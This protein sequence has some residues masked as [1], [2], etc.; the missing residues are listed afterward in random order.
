MNA[1]AKF[2]IGLII[3]GLLSLSAELILNQK[4]PD[5]KPSWVHEVQWQNKPENAAKIEVL[6]WTEITPY[7]TEYDAVNLS[8]SPEGG[9]LHLRVTA[10]TKDSDKPDIYDFVYENSELLPTG[11]LLEA[12]PPAYINEA[13][14]T[15]LGNQTVAASVTNSGNPTVRR[16]LPMTSEKFYEPK[17]LLSVTWEGTSALIDPDIWNVVKIWKADTGNYG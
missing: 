17:T 9:G 8:A 6:L 11:Y 4:Q 5:A 10:T 16:I 14:D 15:A 2:L 12:I 3:L 13:I 7:M 1:A